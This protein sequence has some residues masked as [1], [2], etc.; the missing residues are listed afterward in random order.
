MRAPS[1]TELRRGV[2]AVSVLHDVD[3]EPAELGVVL[4]GTPPV[5][6]PWT[7]CRRA[8]GGHDP[9][10]TGRQRLADWLR[11]RRWAGDLSAEHLVQRLRPVGLPVDHVLHPGLDW[12]RERVLGDALDLGLGAVDLDPA[13][14]DRVVL[15]PSTVLDD[16]GLDQEEM[17]AKTR[18]LLDDLGALAADRLR[19]DTRGLLRPLGDCDV[20]TLL[21][22]RALRAALAADAGGLG[23]AVVPMRNR[24]WTRLAMIDPAFGPAAARA[25]E[26]A[27]RGFDR[28][29][30]VTPDELTVVAEG[31]RPQE[32][33]LRDPALADEPFM[34]D[35]L[36]R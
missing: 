3:V 28:P 30:L 29:L 7:E 18:T 1:K 34:Q 20:V 17:W 36:Y 4:P 23:A 14:P 16:A 12:V 33:V 31:G 19:R 5:W 27:Q 22:S 11:A 9:E 15:L 25:T 10:T 21:G 24:G 32:I 8:L 13:D 2:L 26:P 35:V 6:V